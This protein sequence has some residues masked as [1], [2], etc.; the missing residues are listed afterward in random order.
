MKKVLPLVVTTLDETITGHDPRLANILA[1]PEK[2]K[3]WLEEL[4][5]SG[6]HEY[7]GPYKA[8]YLA[9][10][11]LRHSGTRSKPVRD[12]RYAFGVDDYGTVSGQDFTLLKDIETFHFN[13]PQTPID[14]IHN[15]TTTSISH[16]LSRRISWF[17]DDLI[18]RSKNMAAQYGKEDIIYEQTLWREEAL[19]DLFAT[20]QQELAN[21]REHLIE[22]GERPL[23]T[24][25]LIQAPHPFLEQAIA[26]LTPNSG[27]TRIYL[28]AVKAQLETPEE[29]VL[30]QF[31]L[32]NGLPSSW[33]NDRSHT[34]LIDQFEERMQEPPTRENEEQEANAFYLRKLDLAARTNV[35]R[36]DALKETMA[37]LREQIHEETDPSRKLDLERELARAHQKISIL[38]GH[39][40][41]L[42][43]LHTMYTEH[44]A[45]K[46]DDSP[47]NFD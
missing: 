22:S 30:Q 7:E 18:P 3:P 43:K 12:F 10:I 45:P 37:K 41:L 2:F 24:G 1:Y 31:A 15:Q 35:P 9:A 4:K 21:T 34:N 14:S 46:L 20:L 25:P 23:R 8:A 19:S 29:P 47:L 32:Q 27:P 36:V 33:I 6:E 26:E 39:S 11:L 13:S 28:E 42:N 17:E 44:H 38:V 5:R 16:R 40:T